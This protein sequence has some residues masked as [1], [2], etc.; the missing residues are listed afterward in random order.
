MPENRNVA[1]ASQLFRR[2][3]SYS[4]QHPLYKAL[5]EFGKIQKTNFILKYSDDSEFRQS[6]EKQLNKVENSHKLGKAISVC[7][8]H[9]FLHGEKEDQEIAEGCRRLIKNSLVC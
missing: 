3:N 8:D 1:T 6:I 2:L 5:K 9:S 4:K 7:N